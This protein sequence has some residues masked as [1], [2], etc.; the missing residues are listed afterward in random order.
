MCGI[1]LAYVMI[2]LMCFSLLN[3]YRLFCGNETMGQVCMDVT[4]RSLLHLLLFIITRTRIGVNR[5]FLCYTVFLM[6]KNLFFHIISEAI[7]TPSGARIG[8]VPYSW[9]IQWCVTPYF[10]QL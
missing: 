9:F 3:F 5:H 4:L 1:D 10:L 6:Y 8:H 2:A 7:Y